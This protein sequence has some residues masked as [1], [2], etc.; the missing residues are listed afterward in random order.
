MIFFL[1]DERPWARSLRATQLL[2]DPQF[3]SNNRNT[4]PTLLC[5][6]DCKPNRFAIKL[7]D[8]LE[9]SHHHKVGGEAA[10]CKLSPPFRRGDVVEKLLSD[11]PG[12]GDNK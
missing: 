6:H 12:A 4:Y 8:Y 9:F 2:V 10:T 5:V 1:Y 7:Q 11:S 3:P